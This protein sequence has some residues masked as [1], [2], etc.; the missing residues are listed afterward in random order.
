VHPSS[1]RRSTLG[2]AP[3]IPAAAAV[4]RDGSIL[5]AAPCIPLYPLPSTTA[6]PPTGARPGV[7]PAHPS[8]LPRDAVPVGHDGRP[9]TRWTDPRLAFAYADRD[10]D[11]E[12]RAV[13][14]L[15]AEAVRPDPPRHVPGRP[16][17]SV[18]ELGCGLGAL[19][20]YLADEHW[21]RVYAADVS[22]TMHRL[23]AV[24]YRDA[25]VVRT[26]PDARGRLPLRRAQCTGAIVQ[27]LLLHLAHPC[28]MIGLM[29]DARRV[30]RRGAALA[31]VEPDTRAVGASGT[32]SAEGAA[33]AETYRL[34][35]GTGLVTTA[36]RHSPA[37]IA[38]VLAA[39]GFAVD[40][41]RPVAFD[42]ERLLLYQGRA[43]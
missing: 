41:I 8:R 10:D 18:L 42:E 15:L 7:K 33:Y 13:W 5:P 23:G 6:E 14:P 12:R 29:T 36:W 37:A 20:R 4:G 38:G 30:L 40:A 22:P 17:G 43:V 35:D 27:R 26:L 25:W 32:C 24:R 21:L 19:A 16:D 3:P 1:S 28:L 9:A 34:R 31:V 39:S 2:T 11:A